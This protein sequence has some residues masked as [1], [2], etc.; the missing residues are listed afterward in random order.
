MK[1]W[2]I[3]IGQIIVS[4]EGAIGTIT[5]LRTPPAT[6]ETYVDVDWDGHGPYHTRLITSE[7]IQPLNEGRYAWVMREREKR[8]EENDQS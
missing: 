6:D 5:G 1:L 4:D 3:K 7:R 2:E 8:A